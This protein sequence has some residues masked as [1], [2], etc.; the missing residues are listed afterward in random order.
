MCIARLIILVQRGPF[1]VLIYEHVAYCADL[2]VAQALLASD[3]LSA[4]DAL[5]VVFMNIK[6]M[7]FEN[8]ILRKEIRKDSKISCKDISHFHCQILSP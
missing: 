7:G 5:L 4:S 2:G 1:L 3:A 6:M 8:Y